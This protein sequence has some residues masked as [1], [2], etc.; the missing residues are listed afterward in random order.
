MLGGAWHSK[1]GERGNG[2]EGSAADFIEEMEGSEGSTGEGK[3]WSVFKAVVNGAENRQVN[4]K[5][6]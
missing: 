4:G 3:R 5:R 1:Q 2:I 6:N